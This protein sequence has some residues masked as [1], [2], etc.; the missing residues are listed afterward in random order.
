MMTYRAF[1][2]GRFFIAALFAG[3]V[4]VPIG[5][6]TTAQAHSFLVEATPSSKDHVAASPKTVKLRFGGGVEPAY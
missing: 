1:V 5:L 4:L 3:L 6:V 2:S